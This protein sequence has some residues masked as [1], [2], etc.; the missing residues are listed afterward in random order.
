LKRIGWSLGA[1]RDLRTIAQFYNQ[2]DAA[3]SDR[4]IQEVE[5]AT[6][7]LIDYPQMGPPVAES[8][9]R[10]WRVTGTPFLLFYRVSGSTVRILKVL[11]AR[12]DWKPV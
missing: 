8:A 3:L 4:L 7:I 10:R 11:D 12:S 2:L 5:Q 1:Q 9:L 6:R